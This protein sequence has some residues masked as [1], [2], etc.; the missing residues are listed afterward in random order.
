MRDARTR[1]NVTIARG[2]ASVRAP[3]DSAGQG[4]VRLDDGLQQ[5]S[6]GCMLIVSSHAVPSDGYNRAVVIQLDCDAVRLPMLDDGPDETRQR[7]ND[8][9]THQGFVDSMCDAQA[10]LALMRQT[11]EPGHTRFRRRP[12]SWVTR[13]FALAP[14]SRPR[15][16]D[17]R[18]ERRP[19]SD[20]CAAAPGEAHQPN[21]ARAHQRIGRR[22]R[23]HR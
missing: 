5:M 9:R 2:D 16:A 11:A 15:A 12:G 14:S 13:R 7:E 8:L 17:R 4:T 10:G 3:A 19:R 6:L 20:R 22:L 21:Q 23:D 1:P 18:I